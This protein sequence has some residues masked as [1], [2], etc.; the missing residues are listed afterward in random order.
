MSHIRAIL[1]YRHIK[2]DFRGTIVNKPCGCISRSGQ[3]VVA[4]TRMMGMTQRFSGSSSAQICGEEG[5]KNGK[6]IQL[7]FGKHIDHHFP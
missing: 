2:V 5:A 1:L 7:Q 4:G 6:M 3:S